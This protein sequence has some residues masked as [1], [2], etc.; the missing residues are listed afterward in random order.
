MYRH[1]LWVN[2]KTNIRFFVQE[3]QLQMFGLFPY[4]VQYE[5]ENA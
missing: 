2:Y 3:N 4:L 1:V 5:K